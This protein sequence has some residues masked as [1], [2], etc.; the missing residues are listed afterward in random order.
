MLSR[1]WE[2]PGT[3]QHLAVGY[4]LVSDGPVASLKIFYL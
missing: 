1:R 2:S 3:S 4:R